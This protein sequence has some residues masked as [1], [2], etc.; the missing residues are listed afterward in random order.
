MTPA[1]SGRATPALEH[2]LIS[3]AHGGQSTPIDAP[4]FTAHLDRAA[5]RGS[6]RRCGGMRI[7]RRRAIRGEAAWGTGG[8][9]VPRVGPL[10]RGVTWRARRATPLA[11]APHLLRPLRGSSSGLEYDPARRVPGRPVPRFGRGSP[12][13]SRRHRLGPDL[14]RR[15]RS[16]RSATASR[17]DEFPRAQTSDIG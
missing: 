17:Y 2:Q 9:C 3:V 12:P 6:C 7:S 13:R 8:P 16:T 15:R 1:N 14:S 11:A 4:V 5:A 10:E